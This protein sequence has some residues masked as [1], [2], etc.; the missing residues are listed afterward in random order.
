MQLLCQTQRNFLLYRYATVW[1]DDADIADPA[2][3]GADA[4]RGHDG[5]GHAAAVGLALHARGVSGWLRGPPPAV[6]NESVLNTA[7]KYVTCEECQP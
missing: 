3:G 7:Q 4:A 6:I 1:E 5:G 2:Q